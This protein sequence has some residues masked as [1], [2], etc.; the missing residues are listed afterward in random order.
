[1]A[2]RL[3]DPVR[4]TSF[5]L[6]LVDAHT[7][8]E[9]R[10]SF[11]GLGIALL[12]LGVLAIL[13]PVVASLVS[14]VVIGS[15]LVVSGLLLGVHAV[16]NPRWANSSW[17]LVSA[18]FQIVAGVLIVAFPVTGTMTLTLILAAFFFAD[19]FLRII[20]AI[21]HR[22]MPAWGWL[23]FDGLLSLALGVLI[24]WRWP[25]TAAWA[26][27]LLVGVNL[28][29]SGSSMLLIGVSAR[30]RPVASARV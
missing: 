10:G 12:V 1:M 19:G 30:P 23:L 21:Q 3:E 13:M 27:G 7:V 2:D 6:G 25:S 29:I 20:R 5:G 18:L 11:L 17:S 28:I 22:G 16:R 15:V 26:L 8:Q 24:W 9:N 4:T 14:A